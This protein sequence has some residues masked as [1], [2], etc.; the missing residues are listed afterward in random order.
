MSFR[1]GFIALVLGTALLV[2]ALILNWFRPRV[3]GGAAHGSSDSCLG[4]MR[5]VPPQFAIFR[6][7]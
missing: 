2:G 3:V 1:S 4:Q 7:P 6:R 5:R